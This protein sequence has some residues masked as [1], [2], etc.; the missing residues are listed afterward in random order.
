M[1][2]INPINSAIENHNNGLENDLY[3]EDLSEIS[4]DS[5]HSIFKESED[6]IIK[7]LQEKVDYNYDLY[8]RA[9]AELD[10]AKKRFLRDKEDFIKFANEKLIKEL[11]IVLD[12]LDMAIE[13]SLSADCP[14]SFREGVQLIKKNLISILEKSGLEVIE[15]KGRI[16]DPNFHEAIAERQND[17]EAPGTICEEYQ[18]GY[19]LNGRIL[20]ASKV[21]VNKN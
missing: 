16:F 8:L 9:Q 21:V 7:K 15:A 1:K 5:E 19:C 10:N 2:K 4:G 18:K 6:E 3:I 14:E 17:Q 11:L 20:R 13:C 12:N